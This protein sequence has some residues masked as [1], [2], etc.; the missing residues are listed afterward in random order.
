MK[1]APMPTDDDL[2][3][4]LRQEYGGT[5]TTDALIDV[6][7]PLL[8]ARTPASETK[9]PVW[10]SPT[11]RNPDLDGRLWVILVER[12]EQGKRTGFI[13]MFEYYHFIDGWATDDTVLF[14]LD[15]PLHPLPS[16]TSE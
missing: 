5:A 1:Q 6:V 4:A 13:P 15:S 7:M 14:W 11:D 12:R 2:E 16:V 8:R 9:A 3:A 10:V